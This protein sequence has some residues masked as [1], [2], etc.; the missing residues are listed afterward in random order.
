MNNAPYSRKTLTRVKI[1]GVTPLTPGPWMSSI[2]R[3]R[4][5]CG[6][7]RGSVFR[8]YGVEEGTG[9]EGPLGLQKGR[10]GKEG[11]AQ[12]PF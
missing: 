4:Q 6:S 2:Q 1:H 11:D 7:G 3:V 10:L 12:F 5:W 9:E 8:K